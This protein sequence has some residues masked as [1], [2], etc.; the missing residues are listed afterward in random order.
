MTKKI[1][2][3]IADDHELYRR[4]LADLLKAEG[5]DVLSEAMDAAQLISQVKEYEPDVIITDLLMPGDG[6]KAV[7][8]MVGMGFKRV[9]A[10]SSF[11]NEGLLIEAQDAGA[12]GF[13]RKN[14]D[15][16]FVIRGIRKVYGYEEY[17][18]PSLAGLIMRRYKIKRL[19][20]LLFSPEETEVI[21]MICEGKETAE[22]AKSIFLSVRA[23]E[24]MRSDIKKKMGT[25]TFAG[26]MKFAIQHEIYVI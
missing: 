8:E 5:I 11:E 23:V 4:G 2:V 6:V 21:R 9:I 26:I 25:S 16:E 10:L 12:L 1:R 14:T 24:R 15:N 20:E 22:I 17:Y 3:V 19:P 13:L 18:C 7:K